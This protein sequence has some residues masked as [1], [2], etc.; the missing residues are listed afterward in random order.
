MILTTNYN[1]KRASRK[2]TPKRPVQQARA[3]IVCVG[4]G[5]SISINLLKES[6]TLGDFCASSV[7][8]LA[9]PISTLVAH[10]ERIVDS[11]GL[12]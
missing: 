10:A 8:S 5:I 1:N 9:C 2:G 6:Y 11:L 7:C 4:G 12:S 3:R